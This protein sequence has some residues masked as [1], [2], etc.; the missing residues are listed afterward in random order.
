MRCG[1]AGADAWVRSIGRSAPTDPYYLLTL[2][3]VPA[4][5]FFL[6]N[7]ALGL[8]RMRVGTF[9]WASQLGML[10]GTFLY[11]N[12]GTE[13]GRIAAPRD[14]L[15]PAVLGSLALLG[16]LP[17]VAR[18]A[19]LGGTAAA[20]TRAARRV[21]P[22]SIDPAASPPPPS[23]YVDFKAKPSTLLPISVTRQQPKEATGRR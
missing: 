5:P 20:G 18:T 8:T 13:L 16:I 14:V 4:F 7:I 6:V 2:R 19:C 22:P 9:W 1:A 10:P 12:A 23:T 17:L 11:V 21:D 3:L 15:S